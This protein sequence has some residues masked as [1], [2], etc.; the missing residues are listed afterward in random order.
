[1]VGDYLTTEDVR[2]ELNIQQHNIYS[3]IRRNKLR[4]AKQ[5]P[6]GKLLFTKEDVEKV[7]SGGIFQKYAGY[8][9]TNEAANILGVTSVTIQKY[10]EK[11]YL[12]DVIKPLLSW[13][14]I[15]EK[16]VQELNK[17]TYVREF[18][19]DARL[20]TSTELSYYTGFSIAKINEFKKN[21]QILPV[22]IL[23]TGKAYYVEDALLFLK[24]L[25]KGLQ[26]SEN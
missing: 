14:Y 7:K 21:G 19:S 2:K 17:R 11:G 16:E 12:K 22:R 6:T 26:M 1:M 9:T 5:Y 8:I 25:K 23:P 13:V 20:Y 10:I 24:E 4:V 3:L 15:S 18:A